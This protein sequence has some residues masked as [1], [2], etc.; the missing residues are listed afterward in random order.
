MTKKFMIHYVQGAGGM[1]LSSVFAKVMNIPIKTKISSVGDC[2]DHGNGVWKIYQNVIRDDEFDITTGELKMQHSPG[3]RLYYT[4]TVTDEFIEQNTDIEIIQISA[5]LDDYP[6]I[7]L[8]A[9]KKEWP[10]YWRTKE[11]YNKWVGPD[12]PPYSPNNIAESD[13]ICTDLIDFHIMKRT[14]DWYENYAHI[15]YSHHIDFQTVMGLNDKNLAQEVA[16][17]VDGRVT[18]DILEFI[19]QYQQ[20]NKK[21]YFN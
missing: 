14:T 10:R 7:A 13:L 2:H 15:N 1:F 11:E 20:L 8:L 5:T 12:Y 17:I 18:Q 4:H 21:L 3:N 19:D 6:N 16:T 9:V